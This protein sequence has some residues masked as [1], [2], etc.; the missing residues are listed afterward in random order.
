M[1]AAIVETRINFN[2]VDVILKHFDFLPQNTDL[3]FFTSDEGFN[4]YPKYIDN[5]KF[6][7]IPV[8]NS[9]H[10]YNRL[11]TNLDFWHFPEDRVFIFQCDSMLLR[12]GIEEFYGY[13]FIGAPIKNIAFPAMNGG[14]SLRSQEAMRK[15]IRHKAWTPALG[16]EDI[17]FC[18]VLQ[19]L[20][21]RLP[22]KEI[23]S[24]FSV[25]TVFNLGSLG[26][27]ACEKYLSPQQVD[28]IK[29]QYD[30]K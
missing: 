1:T 7:H 26:Y 11:L 18:N 2:L 23:A 16:N 14:L 6:M 22:S 15:S 27:H 20:G 12:S 10:D 17:Y 28:Q 9:L 3:Y 19:E 5:V 21:G 29:T 25:E 4:Y 30:N 8:I 24:K 13:D